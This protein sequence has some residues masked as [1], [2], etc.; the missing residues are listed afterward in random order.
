MLHWTKNFK[1]FVVSL[2]NMLLI[3]L[4]A[5]MKLEIPDWQ[6]REPKELASPCGC[7]QRQRHKRRRRGVMAANLHGWQQ[8][9]T[10]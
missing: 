10:M 7:S 9:R 8:E 1:K 2:M 4:F 5:S 3:Y 6:S